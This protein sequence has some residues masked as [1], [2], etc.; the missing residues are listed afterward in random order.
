MAATRGWIHPARARVVF[1]SGF[2]ITM[3]KGGAM[4]S[5]ELVSEGAEHFRYFPAQ[6]SFHVLTMIDMVRLWRVM[7]QSHAWSIFGVQQ[8]RS[9]GINPIFPEQSLQCLPRSCT[10][11]YDAGNQSVALCVFSPFQLAFASPSALALKA[12][13]LGVSPKATGTARA[14]EKSSLG[15]VSQ[16]FQGTRAKF[17]CHFANGE[18]KNSY[19][20]RLLHPFGSIWDFIPTHI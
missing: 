8:L 6:S 5:M 15:T 4:A 11:Y 10:S 16:T 19:L 12:C 20:L 14:P 9:G 7:L 3:F 1:A 17:R 13:S 2:G 18:F